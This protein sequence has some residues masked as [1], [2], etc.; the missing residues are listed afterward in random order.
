MPNSKDQTLGSVT[1]RPEAPRGTKTHCR[2]RPA[3]VDP[4]SDG[5]PAHTDQALALLQQAAANDPIDEYKYSNLAW[6]LRGAG[7]LDEAQAA[8]R[9][10]L[11][12]D[13]NVPG[14]HLLAGLVLLA[15]GDPAA[16]LSEVERDKDEDNRRMG[17]AVAYHALGRKADA[18]A[19]LAD[20]ERSYARQSATPSGVAQVHAFRGDIDQA[21]AWLDRAYQQRDA[22]CPWLRNEPLLK[23]LRT[24][25]RYK[26]FLHKMK[27][28]E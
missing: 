20:L 18:D 23:N 4:D 17:R 2:R 16:A 14:T 12:L 26:E 24:D 6:A 9:K 15:R 19:A 3:K 7:K 11:D 8:L 25:L 5:P 10:V 21:F 22:Q 28:P 13:P 1:A 27:L